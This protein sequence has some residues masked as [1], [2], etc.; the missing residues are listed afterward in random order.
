MRPISIG[1]AGLG[2]VGSNL[3]KHLVKNKKN[4]QKKTNLDIVIKYVSA[5]NRSK[6]R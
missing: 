6:K 2:N 3:Y 4:I 5:K 1:L